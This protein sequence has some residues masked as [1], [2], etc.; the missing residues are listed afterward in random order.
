MT[1]PNFKNKHL[2]QALFDPKEF[3]DYKGW[4]K[5]RLPKKI[6]ILY[7]TSAINYFKRKY[8][9]KYEKIKFVNNHVVL[10]YGNVGVIRMTGIGSPHAITIFEE[11]IAMGAKEFVNIG[12]AG[13][14][15]KEGV[16]LCSRAVRDE[17]TSSHYVQHGK[18]AYPDKGLTERLA[19][20]L[21]ERGTKYELA[22]TWT[23]DAPYRETRREVEHYH[24]EGIATVEMEAS[25]L[26]TV[27][28]LRKVKIASAF[29][30]SDVLEK[31]WEP[32]FHQINM[33]R[34]LNRLVDTAIFCLGGKK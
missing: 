27:A 29:V 25:A 24:R 23:I 32:M 34:E 13:G 18:Y 4:D 33:K 7:Q 10:R 15:Q 14:L 21:E 8:R 12:T 2:E 28:K 16:F 1:Y 31:K 9:G 3:V 6:V 11:M 5:H 19:R 20:A 17:G 30:V 22:P 26:F